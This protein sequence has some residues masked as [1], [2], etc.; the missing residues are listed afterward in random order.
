MANLDQINFRTGDPQLKKSFGEAIR[1]RQTEQ[2]IVLT[3][4]VKQYVENYLR[5][6]TAGTHGNTGDI[7]PKSQ[8]EIERILDILRGNMLHDKLALDII[9]LH[10]ISAFETLIIVRGGRKGVQDGPTDQA[11][12]GVRLRRDLELIKK[13]G[14]GKS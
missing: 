1:A 10:L 11:K 6:K 9:K 8:S 14:M 5:E 2:Q 3:D 12:S 13:S 4:F 7:L